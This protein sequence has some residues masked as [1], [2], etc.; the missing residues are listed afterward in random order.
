MTYARITILV[1][2][3][4]RD[5]GLLAE[6]GLAFWIEWGSIR[7]L[8]D[9]GQ[10]QALRGNAGKLGIPIQSAHAVVLSH[11]HYDHTG[12]LHDALDMARNAFVF[13][14]PAAFAP[15]YA[16]NA[17]G[18]ARAI[19]IQEPDERASRGRLT[20]VHG[21]LQI[22]EGL[23]LTGPVPRL[24]DFE[25][26]GGAFFADEG[27]LRPDELPDDQAAF[28]ETSAG[29]VVILGCAHAGVI[30]TLNYVRQL[31]GHRPVHT[32]I[33]GMHLLS[34]GEERMRRTVEE[35]RR[36]EVKQLLP[37]HCTGFEAAARLWREFPGRCFSCPVGGRI[38]L[39]P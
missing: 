12:G 27:C 38:D 21:P 18:T 11:G 39:S 35:L 29:T 17:D 10:G 4:A 13:A 8:F 1:E 5:R 9:T 22:C 30:N 20:W 26:T 24:T 32:V 2:N 37:M 34:A 16:R 33:G 23:H 14:H 6:H 31:T 19:G 7:I 25:D 3:T 15:K 36:L 28:L